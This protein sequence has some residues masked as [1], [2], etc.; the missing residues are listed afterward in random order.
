MKFEALFGD[1][2]VI[3]EYI[4]NAVE[5]DHISLYLP[6]FHYISHTL[7]SHWG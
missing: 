6:N 7:Q 3:T 1:K 2:F 4:A 5:N